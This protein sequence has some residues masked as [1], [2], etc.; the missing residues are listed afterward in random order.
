MTR[1]FNCDILRSEF[2][3]LCHKPRHP[4]LNLVPGKDLLLR[5]KSFRHCG[6]RSNKTPTIEAHA[7]LRGRA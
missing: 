7:L 2:R 6:I 4:V 5:G 1:K 3:P